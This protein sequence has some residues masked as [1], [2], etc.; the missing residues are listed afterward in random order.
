[1]RWKLSA[2]KQSVHCLVQVIT[3]VT[4]LQSSRVSDHFHQD[5]ASV[6]LSN[7]NNGGTVEATTRS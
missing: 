6:I 2:V 5:N 4:S 1:M 3:A 7:E